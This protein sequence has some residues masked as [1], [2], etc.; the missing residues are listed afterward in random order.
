MVH[1]DKLIFVCTDN[2]CL[3]P[4]AEGI[5]RGLVKDRSLEVISRG[6]VV[7]FQEPINPKAAEVAKNSGVKLLHPRSIA[8]AEEDLNTRTLVLTMAEQ[9]K[10]TIYD[11]YES[12]INVYTINEFLDGEGDVEDPLGGEMESYQECF[13]RIC[14]LVNLA[15]EKIFSEEDQK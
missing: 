1:Y 6:L 5:M 2:T 11:Q 9:Q 10:K 8:F 12:A 7:L 3:S 15:A 13:D 4:M 14:I